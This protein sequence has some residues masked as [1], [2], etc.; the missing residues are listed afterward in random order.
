MAKK[1]KDLYCWQSAESTHKIYFFKK[2]SAAVAKVGAQITGKTKAKSTKLS[3]MKFD[4][5]LR[6]R[7]L[8]NEMK[9]KK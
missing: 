9:A 2:R 3:L 4:P 1:V 5:I 7:V 6:K 8:F